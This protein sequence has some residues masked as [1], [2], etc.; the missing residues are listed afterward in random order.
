MNLDIIDFTDGILK[1]YDT[2]LPFRILA[3]ER[4]KKVI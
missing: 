4:I 3:F 2:M 1:D